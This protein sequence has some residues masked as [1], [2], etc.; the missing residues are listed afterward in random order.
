MMGIPKEF[1]KKT[2]GVTGW[3]LRELNSIQLSLGEYYRQILS[4]LRGS[5]PSNF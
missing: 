2:Q 3:W 1:R 5:F 4:M